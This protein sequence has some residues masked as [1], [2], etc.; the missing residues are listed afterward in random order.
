MERTVDVRDSRGYDASMRRTSLLICWFLCA[1]GGESSNDTG[2]GGTSS[3]GTSSG[4]TSSGGTSSGGASSGGTSS[5]GTSSGGTAGST[6]E[7][8]SLAT[9][10]P[11]QVGFA[12]TPQLGQH[13]VLSVA[14]TSLE[15]SGG[16]LAWVGPDL[17]TKFSVGESVVVATQDG[18]DYVEG[19]TNVAC[20]YYDF[21]FVTEL[22]IPD[23][24]PVG[25]S[26][27]YATQCTFEE[28]PGGCGRPPGTGQVYAVEAT[29]GG[30]PLVI[31]VGETKSLVGWEITNVGN[32][33]YPGYGSEDC[34]VEAAFTGAITALGPST[35]GGN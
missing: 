13:T 34:I 12:T 23:P 33:Q 28:S 6:S 18:W 26:L 2:N 14:P 8:E 32:G 17:T 25:P 22:D 11:T 27:V 16:T 7:C 20:A 1:C 31:Q 15:T 21:G 29:T 3:G 19:Q 5:G 24:P 4:G 9:L 30:G 35:I 10:N